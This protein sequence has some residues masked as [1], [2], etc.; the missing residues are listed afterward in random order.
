VNQFEH[1]VSM[2]EVN[3]RL[4]FLGPASDQANRQY[5]KARF[6][7][8]NAKDALEKAKRRTLLSEDCPKV[9]RDG[10]TVAERDAYVDDKCATEHTAYLLAQAAMDTATNTVFAVKE[11][12]SS[13]Q[14]LSQNIRSEASLAGGQR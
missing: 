2:D 9:R 11:Q 7:L 10:W 14:T 1:P 13:A 4:R 6:A 5:E 3:Q 8:A 12:I